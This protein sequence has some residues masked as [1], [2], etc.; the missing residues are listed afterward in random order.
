M[1]FMPLLTLLMAHLNVE[2]KQY[3]IAI[4]IIAIHVT[5]QTPIA[6]FQILVAPSSHS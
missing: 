3:S 4:V 1:L 2:M 6:V 5:S